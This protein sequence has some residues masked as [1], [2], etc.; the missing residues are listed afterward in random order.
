M[1]ASAAK[2]KVSAPTRKQRSGRGRAAGSKSSQFKKGNPGGRTGRPNKITVKQR[3]TARVIFT[4]LAEAG[5]KKGKKHLKDCKVN[6]CVSCWQWAKLA[7]EYV[8][9]KPTQPLEFDPV[10]LRT[11]LESIAV[12]A[13]KTVEE[14]EQEA[15]DAGVRVLA[16]RGVRPG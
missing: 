5:L 8:Y 14:I 10:A 1:A 3:E 6:G 13:N 15:Y 11:E 2:Q 12:A 9:G 7:L 4:P 16:D